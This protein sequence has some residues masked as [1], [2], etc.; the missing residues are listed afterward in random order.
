MSMYAYLFHRRAAEAA[1]RIP[2]HVAAPSWALE[3]AP[4]ERAVQSVIGKQ[5]SAQMPMAKTAKAMWTPWLSAQRFGSYTKQV[6]P[7]R[8][9]SASLNN[10]Q[11]VNSSCTLESVSHGGSSE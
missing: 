1:L 3:S 10:V 4:N 5:V 7:T 6:L 8:S 9:P 2:A 11:Q